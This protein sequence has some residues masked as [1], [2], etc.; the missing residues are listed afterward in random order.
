MSNLKEHYLAEFHQFNQTL[1]GS[2]PLRRQAIERFASLDF[3]TMKS[4]HWRYTNLKRFLATPYV[5]AKVAETNDFADLLQKVCLP[6]AWELV[7]VDG[8]LSLAHSDW[9]ALST[10]VILQPITE[11]PEAF[12]LTNCADVFKAMNMAFCQDGLWLEIPAN[13]QLSK[14]IHCI[15]ISTGATA[16]QMAH[17]NTVVHV[18]ENARVTLL[19]SMISRKASNYFN[20]FM[21]EIKL[22]AKA[23]CD[24]HC[25]QLESEQAF[26]HHQ[27]AVTQAAHSYFA[28]HSVAIGGNLARVAIAVTTDEHSETLL[29]GT[30]LA[31]GEQVQD[32]H[33][34]VDHCRPYGQS[35]SY[36]KGFADDKARAVVDGRIVVAAHAQKTQAEL[37][38]RNLLL[39]SHAEIDAKPELEIYA[40]DV[41]CRHGATIGD[42]DEAAL[43]F[44]QSRGIAFAKARNILLR[45]F[46]LENGDH[47]DHKAIKQYLLA[48]LAAYFDLEFSDEQ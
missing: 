6:V 2:S 41:K 38:T 40:D 18:G 21:T 15:Y 25:C 1:S 13:K 12:S 20:N 22:S 29:T 39:T 14:P 36:F 42:L 5:C 7:F 16:S 37:T 32:H 4:E 43:F 34:L 3:P 45:G 8:V 19:E 44:L 48:Q 17:L 28:G 46:L 27:I 11:H 47:I 30:Y 23:H 9:Q 33:V 10:E 35:A 24:Y 26:H 31:C